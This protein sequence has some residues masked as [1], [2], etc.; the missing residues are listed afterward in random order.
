MLRR[1]HANDAIFDYALSGA[2]VEARALREVSTLKLHPGTP[3]H[4]TTPD[5]W[6]V[7]ERR[8]ANIC[9]DVAWVV[10]ES[11][12]SHAGTKRPDSCQKTNAHATL[13]WAGVELDDA[14]PHPK[15]PAARAPLANNTTRKQTIIRIFMIR[16]RSMLALQWSGPSLCV[17]EELL[18]QQ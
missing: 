5:S 7:A 14:V 2:L 15:N 8:R 10:Y 16:S 11:H 17:R 6:A 18:L 4:S 9:T 13:Q 12:E 1:L 3:R